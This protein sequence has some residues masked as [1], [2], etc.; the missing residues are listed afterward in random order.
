M[1]GLWNFNPLIRVENNIFCSG[2]LSN[3]IRTFKC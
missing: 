2:I 1:G 3:R